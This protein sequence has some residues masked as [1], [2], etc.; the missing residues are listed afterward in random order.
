MSLNIFSTRIETCANTMREQMQIF[1]LSLK[2]D[3]TCK[4][5]N[6]QNSIRYMHITEFRSLHLWRVASRKKSRN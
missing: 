1:N 4:L 5:V 3:Y 6:T 2:A